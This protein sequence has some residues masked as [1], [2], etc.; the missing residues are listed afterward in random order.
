MRQQQFQPQAAINLPQTRYAI[1]L[2]YG[3]AEGPAHA[4]QVR[5]VCGNLD[6]LLRAVGTRVPDAALSYVVAF[7][8]DVWDR[9][10]GPPRPQELHPFREFRSGTRF[11]PA[12]PGDLFFHVTADDLGIGYELAA[13]IAGQFGDSVTPIDETHGFRYFDFRD[14]TGFVDG[15]ENPVGAA[16]VAAT[17]IDA[18]DPAFAGGSYVMVQKYLHD[19]AAWNSLP[20]ETQEGIIGRRKLDD[21]E[22]DDA[23]KPAFAHNALTVVEENGQ[24]IEIRRHNMPFG[25]AGGGD[26][27]T[28]FIGYARSPRP[29]EMM[30]E[31]MVVGRPPGNYDRLLD[32]THPITGS[33][34]F[35]PSVDFLAAL[36]TG[37]TVA[38]PSPD[39]TSPDS[40]MGSGRSTDGSL[41]IGSLKGAPQHE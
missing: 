3:V 5:R 27:G 17:I 24:E 15:T 33:L 35:A 41:N 12:T 39:D 30:L 9:L 7:G 36:A 13:Q 38:A 26:S 34:F 40:A 11:A 1:F 20:T 19:H 22:L 16:S 18:E 21:V 8:S 37:D 2:V 25:S 14:L 23:V 31:N 6:A 10:F 4:E 28:Y 29:M 32:F